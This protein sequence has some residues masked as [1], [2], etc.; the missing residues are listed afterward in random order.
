MSTAG[1]KD[2][3]SVA[4]PLRAR[5]RVALCRR[6][7]VSKAASDEEIATAAA[8]S[9]LSADI[10]AAVLRSPLT[11]DDLIAVGRSAAELASS[12]GQSVESG[13]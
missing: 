12:R 8:A 13:L 9:G 5:A 11:A 10:V 3:A 6:A 2:L 4:E 7:G 1:P